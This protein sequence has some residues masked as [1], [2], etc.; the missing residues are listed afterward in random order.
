VQPRGLR[1]P[2]VCRRLGAAA[3]EIVMTVALRQ[4]QP[5]VPYRT[6]PHKVS[7]CVKQV[8]WR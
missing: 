4:A 1:P 5:T 3:C 6:A 8:Q 7:R 2:Q